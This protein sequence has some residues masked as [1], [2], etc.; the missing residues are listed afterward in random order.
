MNCGRRP[1]VDESVLV[2]ASSAGKLAG[3]DLDVFDSGL[4]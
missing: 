2:D 3:T 1:V 4:L